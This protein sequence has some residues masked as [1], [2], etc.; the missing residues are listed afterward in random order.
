MGEEVELA[1]ALLQGSLTGGPGGVPKGLP[2]LP[3]FAGGGCAARGSL[4]TLSA[5]LALEEV[6]GR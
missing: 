3:G 5:T 1:A 2:A 6:L 4:Q